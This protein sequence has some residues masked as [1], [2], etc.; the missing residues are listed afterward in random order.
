MDP[1]EL[2]IGA[3]HD[4]PAPSAESVAAA[5]RT[6]LAPETRALASAV[7]AAMVRPGGTTVAAKLLR[8]LVGR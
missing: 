4:G 5:L 2:G 3:A 1:T 8:E 6:A 7:A